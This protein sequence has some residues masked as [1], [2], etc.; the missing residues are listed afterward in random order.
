MRNKD[1]RD[2]FLMSKY[3][4]Y[5][6]N[7]TGGV[8]ASFNGF[9]LLTTIKNTYTLSMFNPVDVV[10]LESLKSQVDEFME[11]C[12]V[13]KRFRRLNF[14]FKN[15]LRFYQPHHI[16]QGV[17]LLDDGPHFEVE[18]H[19]FYSLDEVEKVWNNRAFL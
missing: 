17:T 1:S 14:L 8:M 10:D 9:E 13:L 16:K 19:V 2:I 5:N 4:D 15:E 7:T 18:G 6:T 11:F 3:N 12:V